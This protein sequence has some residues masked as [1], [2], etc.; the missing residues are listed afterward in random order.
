MDDTTWEKYRAF[1]KSIPESE[2]LRMQE[3]NL[4]EAEK[5]YKEFTEAFSKGM[6]DSCGKPVSTFSKERPCFHWLLRP[7]KSKKEHIEKGRR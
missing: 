3:E 2:R 6:C 1:V 7:G 4:K 5:L